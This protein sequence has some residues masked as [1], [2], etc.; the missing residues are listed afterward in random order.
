MNSRIPYSLFAD[1]YK[2][3]IDGSVFKFDPNSTQSRDAAL[4]A[5]DAHGS[6]V[7]D[8]LDRRAGHKLTGQ[9]LLTGVQ[10]PELR[11]VEK[12][13]VVIPQTVAPAVNPAHVTQREWQQY[14]G[15]ETP[16]SATARWAAEHDQQQLTVEQRQADARDPERVRAIQH[17]EQELQAAKYNPDYSAEE[18]EQFEARVQVAKLGSLDDYSSLD[19]EWRKVQAEKLAESVKPIDD[20]ISLLKNRKAE[21]ESGIFRKPPAPVVQF[22][23]APIVDTPM[24]QITE[25]QLLAQR[26]ATKAF[27]S[28]VKEAR[29]AKLPR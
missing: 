9:E 20:R 15:R 7:I 18:M 11:P 19:A 27:D 17:A 1:H 25:G 12:R 21:I 23:E 10:H 4:A 13:L 2:F 8:V 29:D 22:E 16:E 6:A 3:S 5:L 26:A 14:N 24:E 28:R